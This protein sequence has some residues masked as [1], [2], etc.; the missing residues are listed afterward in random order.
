MS[1]AATTSIAKNSS[2]C[3]QLDCALHLYCVID[4]ALQS[5]TLQIGKLQH[6]PDWSHASRYA[7]PELSRFQAEQIGMGG[8]TMCW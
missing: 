5:L 4:C 1:T 7:R 2:S 8:C 6:H 3:Q